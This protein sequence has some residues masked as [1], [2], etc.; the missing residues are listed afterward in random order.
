MHRDGSTVKVLP[1]QCTEGVEMKKL[2]IAVVDMNWFPQIP[3]WVVDDVK[4]IWSSVPF[5]APKI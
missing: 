1:Y 4:S 3:D 5:A 2:W